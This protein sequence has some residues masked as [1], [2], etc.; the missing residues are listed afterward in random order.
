M[1]A[2]ALAIPLVWSLLEFTLLAFARS[3]AGQIGLAMTA[4]MIFYSIG[5]NLEIL[6]YLMWPGLIVMGM[7]MRELS[8]PNK[9][10]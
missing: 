6:A 9:E 4:L 1:G 8:S 3:R 7:A 10:A 5:E 2:T